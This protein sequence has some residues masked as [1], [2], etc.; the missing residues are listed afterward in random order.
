MIDRRIKKTW[1][2]LTFADDLGESHMEII[3][4]LFETFL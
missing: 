4:T 3:Y 2:V 1:S